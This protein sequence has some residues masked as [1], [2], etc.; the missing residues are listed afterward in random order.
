MQI[1]KII[2]NNVT[3][4]AEIQQLRSLSR[5][6]FHILKQAV[7]SQIQITLAEFGNQLFHADD[8]H[9][10][11]YLKEESS[12]RIRLTAQHFMRMKINGQKKIHEFPPKKGTNLVKC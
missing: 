5:D 10:I 12:R 1:V 7:G 4:E 3:V 8:A 2:V 11:F 9:K 6:N